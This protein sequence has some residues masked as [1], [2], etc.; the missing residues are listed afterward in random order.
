MRRGQSAVTIMLLGMGLFTGSILGSLNRMQTQAADGRPVVSEMTPAQAQQ[1]KAQ[2]MQLRHEL[3][4]GSGAQLLGLVD[5]GCR[6]ISQ[7]PADAKLQPA[8]SPT[9]PRLQSCPNNRDHI[10]PLWSSM[11]NPA[12]MAIYGKEMTLF[13]PNISLDEASRQMRAALTPISQ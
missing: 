7:S 13:L 10:G 3:H 5:N 8:T 4:A 2:V 6:Y 9:D 12:Q 11:P 1:L